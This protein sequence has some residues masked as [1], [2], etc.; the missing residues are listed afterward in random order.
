MPRHRQNTHERMRRR[1]QNSGTGETYE[2]TKKREQLDQY[3]G[4][5]TNRIGKRLVGKLRTGNTK[6]HAIGMNKRRIRRSAATSSIRPEARW[7]NNRDYNPTVACK[8]PLENCRTTLWEE[9]EE[10]DAS[11]RREIS[12]RKPWRLPR[13]VFLLQAHTTIR[14][15]THTRHATHNAAK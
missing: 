7:G 4:E 12:V 11:A 9:D 3:I 8:C 2:Q 15:S 10:Q 1:R 13:R 6:S 14:T 5:W